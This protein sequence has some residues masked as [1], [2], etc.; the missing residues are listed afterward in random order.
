[1]FRFPKEDPERYKKWLEICGLKAGD[2]EKSEMKFLCE[3]HF[4]R[5][6]IAR[7]SRRKMLLKTAIPMKLG[8]TDDEPEPATVSGNES[9]TRNSNVPDKEGNSITYVNMEDLLDEENLP[10]E[11]PEK[12]PASA[13][14][15]K[16]KYLNNSGSSASKSPGP[17]AE[18]PPKLVSK[19]SPKTKRIMVTQEE[20][21]TN[22]RKIEEMYGKVLRVES[23]V[24]RPQK[25]V[26][27]NEDQ[28]DSIQ[29]VT[30][31]SISTEKPEQSSLKVD[32]IFI[33]DVKILEP[34]PLSSSEKEEPPKTVEKPDSR[35]NEFI[36]N[37]EMYVQ[38]PK[39][40]FNE[41]MQEKDKLLGEI[42]HYKN[43][44]KKIGDLVPNN[45]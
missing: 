45:L 19:K 33:D 17:A 1:M 44:L 25:V 27:I 29:N 2:T 3:K 24:K 6:Y 37:G 18:K 9:L 15:Y 14:L 13:K 43:L 20:Y 21:K 22:K 5:R 23:I 31:S 40:L 28:L 7:Q 12:S 30:S 38:M 42:E 8:E 11:S 35:I 26:I 16:T 41:K 34:G 36:F 39:K 4:S 10:K 32:E